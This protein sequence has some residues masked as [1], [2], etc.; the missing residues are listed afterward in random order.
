MSYEISDGSSAN[1]YNRYNIDSEVH[2]NNI[3]TLPLSCYDCN[4]IH[5]GD[6]CWGHNAANLSESG[7]KIR[8]CAT[9]QP[10][11]KVSLNSFLKLLY[12]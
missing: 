2:I 9:N 6:S 12:D 3:T 11:C 7:L 1:N 5:D 10:Y 8:Q 4:S